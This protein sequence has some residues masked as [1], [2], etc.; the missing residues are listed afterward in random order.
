MHCK[1][2]P[3][4]R[5]FLSIKQADG[6]QIEKNIYQ[7]MNIAGLCDRLLKKRPLMFMMSHDK[8]LL[9]DGRGGTGSDLF[10][11]V[12]TNAEQGDSGVCMQNMQTY[13]EMQISALIAVSTPTFFINSGGRNN[14]A[15]IGHEGSFVN[16]G[17][18]IAQVGAR[19]ERPQH[20]EWRHIVVAPDQ[21]T[22]DNGY[23][24]GGDPLLL[25]W[26]RHIYGVDHFPDVGG[27]SSYPRG[28]SL[29][30]Q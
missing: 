5:R 2:V 24:P 12:G 1:V 20:M 27:G 26:A 8:Y 11:M 21:N 28:R 30:F 9:R 4:M 23:G 17:I 16:H 18:V 19:F 7:G 29:S 14:R 22:V 13:D 10:D 15:I 3:L 25:A 6:S